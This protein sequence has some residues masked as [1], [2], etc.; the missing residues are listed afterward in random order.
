[1]SKTIVDFPVARRQTY[2]FLEDAR[3]TAHVYLWSDVDASALREAR[4]ASGGKL[5]YVSFVVK[6]AADVV[7]E[8]PDARAVLETG[9]EPKLAIDDEVH[10]KVMFDKTVDGQRCVMTGLVRS[11]QERSVLEVQD[12]IDTYKD[13]PADEDGPFAQ[14]VKM[15]RMPLAKLRA[16]YRQVIGDPAGRA[17]LQ[18]TFGV[19]SIGHEKV[20]GIFP[21]IT[22]T[23]GFGVGNIADTPVVREGKLAI[24]PVFSL[25]LAFDHRVLDGAMAS[26]VLA[27]VKNRLETWELT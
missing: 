7:A 17:E 4:K 8:Y 5:S 10:A 16:L 24:A 2:V 27:R 9:P 23:L 12:Q 14:I 11:A 19:T 26:E 22:G 3:E 18:G 1:V 13:A 25:S 20:R 6:A 21:M 15:Q